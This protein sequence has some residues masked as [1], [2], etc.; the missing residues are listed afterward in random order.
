[1]KNYK[2]EFKAQEQFVAGFLIK[3][4]VSYV[5]EAQKE[6]LLKDNYAKDLISNNLLKIET[7]EEIEIEIESKKVP[8][9]KKKE[10]TIIIDN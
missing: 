7:V 4:G 2:I 10:R 8:S 9:K 3:Q 5:N 6:Q 1:M